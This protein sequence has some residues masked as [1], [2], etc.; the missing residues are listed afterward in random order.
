LEGILE[1]LADG[2]WEISRGDAKRRR[3]ETTR[4][5]IGLGKVYRKGP[6]TVDWA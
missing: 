6:G 5:V 1:V 3:V 2:V 4:A